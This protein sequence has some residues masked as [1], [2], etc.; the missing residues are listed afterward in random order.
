MLEIDEHG[1][2]AVTR[3]LLGQQYLIGI[4]AAQAVWRKDQNRLNLSIG[5]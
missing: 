2:D 5:G 4:L 1:L 3:E